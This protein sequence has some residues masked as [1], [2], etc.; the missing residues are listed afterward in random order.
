MKDK[1]NIADVGKVVPEATNLREI[2]SGGFKVVY[3][4]EINGKPE[5]VKLVCIPGDEKD[6]SV[7][8][9][10]LRRIEREIRIL[11]ECKTPH[12]VKLG[13]ITPRQSNIR[14]EVFVLYSEE[15]IP[16]ESL[17]E[18]L[19]ADHKPDLKELTVVGACLLRAI[20]ELARKGLIHRDIKPDNIMKTA[21]RKRSYVLLDL[22]IAFQV[23][24]TPITRDS[25]RIPGTLY[26]IAPEML[27][28]GFRQNLDYR[29]DLYTIGLTLYEYASGKNPFRDPS[30][31]EFTT[32]YRIKTVTPT[33]LLKRRNDLPVEF[34]KLVDQLMRKVPALRPSN[35]PIL[36]RRMEDF[37]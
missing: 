18:L 2:G 3:W 16:G 6:E 37:Q 35:I 26:Y 23:G 15:F 13:S 22:G 33:P 28:S 17:R 11:R 12:L 8:E 21:V 25:G 14:G 36:L 27:E 20:N 34:C 1:P 7:R 5:A 10:N 24:G 29:A 31:T 32:L 4:A 30:D 19:V 9:E